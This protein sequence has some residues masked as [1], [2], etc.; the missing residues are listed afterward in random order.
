[1]IRQF[2]EIERKKK[3]IFGN[4]TKQKSLVEIN[5]LLAATDENLG[6][7]IR[8]HHPSHLENLWWRAAL[9]QLEVVL[10]QDV[11][12]SNLDLIRSKEASGT[13]LFPM[14]ETEMLRARGDKI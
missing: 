6:L 13:G 8:R 1:M 2:E 10:E 11:R 4:I 3:E 14:T 7:R 5:L 12:E 9:V